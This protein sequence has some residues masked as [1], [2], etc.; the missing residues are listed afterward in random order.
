M[1]I[2]DLAI[3]IEEDIRQRGLRRGDRYLT[4]KEVGER[5]Q[6]S[7]VTA[8]RAMV[9]LTDKD[10]VIRKRKSGTFVGAGFV[11]NPESGPEVMHALHVVMDKTYSSSY[12]F[13][14]EAFNN[15]V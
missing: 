3:A 14:F 15:A 1:D 2:K 10:V 8:H 4:A 13:V 6:V 5:F 11:R 7:T 12:P 9:I